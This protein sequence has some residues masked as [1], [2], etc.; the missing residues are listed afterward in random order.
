MK[1]LKKTGL[2]LLGIF[3]FLLILAIL[4]L[5]TLFPK[6]DAAP[7]LKVEH[8]PE[9]IERGSY[10]ANA[11]AVCMDCHSQRDWSSY[12]GPMVPG[13]L[14]MGGERF[15]REMG[16]PGVFYSKNITPA[17]L[18]GWTDGEIYRTITSGVDR[19][20]NALFPVMP[21]HSYNQLHD[22]DIYSIISYLRSLD[23]IENEIPKRTVDFPVNLLIR[24]FP[25]KRNKVDQI[26]EKAD[27]VAYGRYVTT[28][29]G[30]IDC[31]TPVKKGNIILE[32]MYSGGRAFEMPGGTLVSSNL[33]PHNTGIANWT[34]AQFISTFKQYQDSS[35][36][37][38]KL[39]ATDMNTL[40]PWMMYSTMK[41]EDLAAI[42]AYL[43]S[44]PPI[45]RTV[46]KF[47]PKN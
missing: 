25:S 28:M 39:G 38:P 34:E 14:G 13:T 19:E 17:S 15:S 33:T 30:C 43:K 5:F 37:S 27:K 26:P 47:I 44:L 4:T 2:Y 3:S 32:E 9:R 24:T 11:V 1:T 18:S 42:F 31:H 10:I 36:V 16:F 8:T 40:M 21:F 20:G 7:E 6:V 22:E 29:A 23:P 46:Q 12:A 41:E 45:E 35:Y